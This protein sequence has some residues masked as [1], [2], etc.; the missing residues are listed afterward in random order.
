MTPD[1]GIAARAHWFS[2][3]VLFVLSIAVAACGEHESPGATSEGGQPVVHVYNWVD[4]VAESTIRDF[5]AR[6]GIKVVY[7]VYD[8]N[9]V[10]QTKLL[11]GHSGYDV[12][13]PA[14]GLNY[15]LAQAGILTKLDKSK[16]PNYGNLDPEIMRLVAANDPD[17]AYAIPYLR[18]TTGIGYNPDRVQQVLGTRTIDSLAAIFDPTTA[19]RLAQCGITWLDA[20]P[21]MFSLA[22]IYLQRDPNSEKPEDVAAAEAL[23]T[24]A[25]PYVRYF[26][27]SQHVND[28]ASGE[29]CVSV[30]WSGGIQQARVRGA[31]A[32]TPVDVVY[33]IPKEGAPLWCDMAAIPIDAPHPANAY[34]FLNY[35]MEPRVIAEIT[36]TVGQASGNAAATQYVDA[37]IR[38]D[39]SIYMGDEVMERLTI[40]RALSDEH[41]RTLWRAW[42]RIRTG[43]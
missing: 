19:S 13:F 30:G 5:E 16:L 43:T 42:N 24:R 7:D 41:V 21:D 15:R 38:D 36:N 18:G 28:L 33:V 2:R 3:I 8:S 32:A 1:D 26:H 9:E 10:L 40:D 39:P 31:E 23:L 20:P 37:A 35:L 25:R 17:N 6:T 12:V 34:A 4:Y 27:S 14:G 22:L 11:V 29:V